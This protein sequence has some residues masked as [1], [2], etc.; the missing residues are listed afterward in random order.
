MVIKMVLATVKYLFLA[1]CGLQVQ[2]D[3]QLHLYSY[4][5][6]SWVAQGTFYKLFCASAFS[7]VFKCSLGTSSGLVDSA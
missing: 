7:P 1:D 6:T 3:P 4:I 2:P 5:L